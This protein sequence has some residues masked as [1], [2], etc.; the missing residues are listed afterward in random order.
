MRVVASVNVAASFKNCESWGPP[1]G[2]QEVHDCVAC[3][4]PLV[5]VA[6]IFGVL[7]ISFQ[8]ANMRFRWRSFLTAYA[9]IVLIVLS[10][11]V[12]FKL[13]TYFAHLCAYNGVCG[14]EFNNETERTFNASQ[15]GRSESIAMKQNAAGKSEKDEPILN[16]NWREKLDMIGVVQNIIFYCFGATG[17][18]LLLRAAPMFVSLCERWCEVE[19]GLA[20]EA[21]LG[22][23]WP[24]FA[25][26]S[27]LGL[28]A[29]GETAAS[30][31]DDE[32]HLPSFWPFLETYITLGHPDIVEVLG[33][34]RV[35]GIVM[36]IVNKYATFLWN[37]VDIFIANIAFVLTRHFKAFNKKLLKYTQGGGS[38]SGADVLGE[39][40][41]RGAREQHLALQGLVEAAD[42]VTGPL[43][44]QSFV[45]NL[46]FMLMQ[47]YNGLK[48]SISSTMVH[49]LYLAWSFVHLLCRLLFVSL[50]CASLHAQTLQPT[51]LLLSLPA[52]KWNSEAER[53]LQ[54][55]QSRSVGLTGCGF[56]FVNKSFILATTGALITYEVILLQLNPSR[57]AD[58]A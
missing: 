12:V 5:M 6:R 22:R 23:R 34:T 32:E 8:G 57:P 53:F 26:L 48:P 16:G 20:S 37:F 27:L 42:G 56:F 19:D 55:L 3:L 11:Y 21:P 31:I 10:A 43:V 15:D 28:S 29:V 38:V 39:R 4:R 9:L 45:C 49:R 44:L 40:W 14:V 50:T 13:T 24:L 30:M 54:Q 1:A 58:A 46:F 35:L 52:E 33:Y 7:P 41:W 36:L 51:A 47:L 2:S 18:F 17:A 25:G